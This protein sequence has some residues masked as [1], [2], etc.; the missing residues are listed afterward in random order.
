[1]KRFFTLSVYAILVLTALSNNTV[2]A[3]SVATTAGLTKSNN[4][5]SDN[6]VNVVLQSFDLIKAGNTVK[7]N[8]LTTIEKNNNYFEIQR[9]IDGIQFDVIAL[10]FAK[11]DA[12]KGANYK[13]HDSESAK[14]KA[15]KVY[16]RLRI[17]DIK[18]NSVLLDPQKIAL[19]E[20]LIPQ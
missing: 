13:Y 20:T 7:L 10:M 11:E 16:Y 6:A 12:E 2:N 15:D 17:I 14:L 9:S 4:S 3:Q 8:W 18:G 5:K 19:S 1:M